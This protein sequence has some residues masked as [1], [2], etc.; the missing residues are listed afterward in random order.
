MSNNKWTAGYAQAELDAAQDRFGF[1]FPPD[2][3][4]LLREKRPVRGHNWRDHSAIASAMR[5]PLEGLLFDVEQNG[6]WW[7][8]W[9]E[10]P[11]RQEARKEIVTSVVSQ[12]PLLIPLFAHRYLPDTPNEAGNPVFSVHQSD[13]IYYG[14]DLDDYFAREFDGHAS[15][16]W[17]DHIKDI[18][19][20][21]LAESRG[22]DDA[23]YQG[24]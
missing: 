13:I 24:G 4:D 20:W 16:P 12:A 9:G 17:P 3:A 23:Y 14:S 22:V 1:A 15:R 7:P 5:W 8:E 2:L 19:F 18:P 11:V 21:S 10:K 6:L